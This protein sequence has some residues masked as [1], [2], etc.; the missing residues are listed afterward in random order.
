MRLNLTVGV[1]LQESQGI[2]S[3]VIGAGKPKHHGD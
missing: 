3:P 2:K 1:P